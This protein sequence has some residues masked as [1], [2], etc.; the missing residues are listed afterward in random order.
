MTEDTARQRL[1]RRPP[2]VVF[3]LGLAA[4]VEMSDLR[5]HA[6]EV[7]ERLQQ[8]GHQAFWVGGCVR[9]FLLGQEPKDYDI[10]TSARPDQIQQLFSPTRAVG[11]QF[12]VVLVL[13][14][15]FSF[16]VATFRAEE[17]YLDGR[18]PSSITFST[19]EADA[20][21]RDFTVNGLFYDPVMQRLFDWVDG[22]ADLKTRQIRTIGRSADR[23][24]EDHLRLLRAIRFAAALG[25]DVEP[26]TMAA[27]QAA[28]ADITSVSAERIRDELLRLV[29]PPHAARGLEL[30]R[31]SSLLGQV[32]PELSDTV[33]CEQPPQYHPE[34]T[35]YQHV[36]KTL[37]LMPLEAPVPLIWA[38]LLH[39]IG[40]PA[41][42]R[43][44]PE[45]GAVH[46]YGHEK[47]GAS[48]AETMLRRLRFPRRQIDQIVQCV[49]MHMQLK[50]APQMRKSTLR[51]VLMRPSFPIEL[52]LHRLDCLASHGL[53]DIHAFLTRELN[54][55][56]LTPRLYPPLIT[57]SDLLEM[58][59][60][61]GPELGRL[62]AEIREKQL[63]DE[64]TT[65]EAARHFARKKAVLCGPPES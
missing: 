36:L 61:E 30:L 44:H 53:M 57:G 27:I 54:A 34:G 43:L 48:V 64:L 25:F 33:D 49:R 6:L 40:K 55:L 29:R 2:C 39:D 46:F 16:E 65:P 5:Q 3:A 31:T 1:A 24:A 52:E 13:V 17:D 4:M 45:D 35:V 62:L 47:V 7:V 9:D 56:R 19:A 58:G 15:H 42:R 22:E 28:A 20:Q 60:K 18:H 23:F 12:G 59:L 38:A 41:T 51:R 32:L 8:A 50:D 26:H 63:L 37:E 11:K 14:D 21:R 10:A